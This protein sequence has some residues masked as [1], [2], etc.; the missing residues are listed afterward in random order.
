MMRALCDDARI[1]RAV[2]TPPA[3]TRAVLR[4]AFVAHAEAAPVTWSCDWTQLRLTAPVKDDVMS[5]DPFDAVGD[6]R[7]ARLLAL[8]DGAC[9][10]GADMAV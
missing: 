4:G 6:E 2:T 7:Y 9:G 10:T 1:E 8:I 3:G 5:L